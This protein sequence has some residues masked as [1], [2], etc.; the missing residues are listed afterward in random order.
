MGPHTR[1]FEQAVVD[2]MDEGAA[3]RAPSPDAAFKLVLQ[4][5]DEP[6]RIS[7]MGEAGIHW[8]QK[9][10]GAVSRVIATLDKLTGDPRA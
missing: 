8:V 10:T 5:L 3:L 4:L 6:Q 2:A 1:N 7:R 9:H